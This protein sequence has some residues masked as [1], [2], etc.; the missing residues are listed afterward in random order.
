MITKHINISGN[1]WLHQDKPSKDLAYLTLAT[2]IA[3]FIS[4]VVLRPNTEAILGTLILVTLVTLTIFLTKATTTRIEIDRDKG[5]IRTTK[6]YLVIT[7]RR[8]VPLREFDSILMLA[9][10]EP[11]EDG[12]RIRQYTVALS[13]KGR[14]LELL[15]ADSEAE[16]KTIQRELAEFLGLTAQDATGSRSE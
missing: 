1:M 10:D 2:C 8:R 12:Y 13:G 16:G 7:L 11:V 3:A 9:Q 4:V 15:S 14:S 5:E 6:K